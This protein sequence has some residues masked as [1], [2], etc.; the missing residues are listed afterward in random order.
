MVFPKDVRI[1]AILER[2]CLAGINTPAETIEYCE[3]FTLQP[4][5]GW[6]VSSV[7]VN[8]MAVDGLVRLVVEENGGGSLD[9][10]LE[11]APAGGVHVID[12]WTFLRLC[13]SFR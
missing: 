6:S 5:D 9:V 10:L 7:R 4:S 3:S 1:R 13:E 11:L 2:S 12:V 8:I